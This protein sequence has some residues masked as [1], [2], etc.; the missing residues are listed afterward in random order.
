MSNSSIF[1]EGKN[2]FRG[3]SDMAIR[4]DLGGSKTSDNSTLLRHLMVT[5]NVK[6]PVIYESVA[7]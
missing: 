3:V 5:E 7:N 1:C 4:D 6:Y 2:D